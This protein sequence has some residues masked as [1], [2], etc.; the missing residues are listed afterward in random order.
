MKRKISDYEGEIVNQILLIELCFNACKA[1]PI[2]PGLG[3]HFNC[4]F[5]NLNMSKGIASLHSL[6]KPTKG[7]ISVKN[8]TK[9]YKDFICERI[10]YHD[11]VKKTNNIEKDSE[12]TILN[13]RHKVVSHLDQN[14]KHSDFVSGYMFTNEFDS[15]KLEDLLKITNE[16]KQVFFKFTNWSINQNRD[17]V[18]D[19]IIKI[20]ESINNPK[21]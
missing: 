15:K 20:V 21:K 1:M 3:S 7:E 16:L 5:F 4:Y 6:L 12:E 13:M 19:Q 10:D 8:Y 18:L 17:D 9:I 14:F 2:K 11:F